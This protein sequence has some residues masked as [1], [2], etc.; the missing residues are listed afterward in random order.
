M[1]VSGVAGR[2]AREKDTEMGRVPDSSE[3]RG[4]PRVSVGVPRPLLGLIDVAECEV[5]SSGS[6]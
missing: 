4:R 1:R 3:V 2:G 6:P 5:M